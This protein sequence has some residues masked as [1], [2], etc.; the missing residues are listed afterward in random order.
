MDCYVIN[1]NFSFKLFQTIF[2][3]HDIIVT[4]GSFKLSNSGSHFVIGEDASIKPLSNNTKWTSF[5][6]FERVLS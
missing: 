2:R 4:I 6:V 3:K 1:R 5:V